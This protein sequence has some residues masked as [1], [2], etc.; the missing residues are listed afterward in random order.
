MQDYCNVTP[1][2]EKSRFNPEDKKVTKK[3]ASIR[4]KITIIFVTMLLVSGGGLG[5]LAI[6][7]AR[8]AVTEKVEIHLVDKA[9]DTANL[10]DEKISGFFQYMDGVARLPL[11]KNPAVSIDEKTTYLKKEL[12]NNPVFHRLDL[13]DMDGNRYVDIG[14]VVN[15]SNQE[16]YQEPMK[17]KHYVAD[18]MISNLDKAYVTFFSVPVYFDDG[19][20]HGVLVGSVLAEHLAG[21]LADVVVGETGYCY[22]LNGNADLIGHKD[23]ERS[24]QR[25]NPV[26]MAEKDPAYASTA[27][28]VK[29]ALSGTSHNIGF[30][31]FNG[32]KIISS[33]ARMDLADWIIFISAPRK[34]FMG[35][36]NKLR[37]NIFLIGFSIF[38]V[39]V[40][41]IYFVSR[42]ISS[43]IQT[44]TETLKDIANGDGDLT[45]RL[46]VQGNDE[47]TDLAIYFNQTI[48]KI[49]HSVATVAD[50]AI[51]M[52]NIGNNL[53]NNM[54]QTASSVNE[55]AAN[56][57]GVKKQ[58]QNQAAS[59]T[60]T[61]STMEEILRTIQNL[62]GSIETQSASVTQSSAAVE[63]MAGNIDSIT[64]IL[65]KNDT[66]VQ[67]LFN[68]TASGKKSLQQSNDVTQK[69]SKASGGLID[70]SNV[71]QS[72]ASQTN[73]LAMNAAIEAAH[74][75]DAGKGFAVVA[76]EI[77]KLAEE[78]SMQAKNITSVLT[79]LDTEID[80]LLKSS[81]VV[82]E[83]FNS[84]MNLSEQVKNASA[85]IMSAMTEQEN[86]TREVLAAIKSINSVTLEVKDGSLEMYKGG[87]KVAKEM[88]EL[89]N[90]TRII[91]ESMNEMATGVE[92]VNN[93]VQEVNTISIKNK[94]S[95]GVL[96]EV[97]GKFKI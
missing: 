43:S 79:S 90:L 39:S 55:I 12:G 35:A 8:L 10:L 56:I 57:N 78:S 81:Q 7:T 15:V 63:Q 65:S 95:I 72:I 16:F 42:K 51:T 66:S 96:S 82:E 88:R 76:D 62:N 40:I 26:K 58:T 32:V 36:I 34:E 71:I 1:P 14:H 92:Q 24:R 19:K 2:P 4:N 11:I 31:E 49:R 97:V 37:L 84:I 83:E 75:G 80:G 25:P 45:A 5:V 6:R 41:T 47:M 29:E 86:G 93:A 22:V 67:E 28:F 68:A 54:M 17:G 70:A 59:V 60:E 46:A 85:N 13:C 21:I 38:I 9:K 77:R 30:Y 23:L 74:A 27:K 94:E 89:Q 53:A 64:K 73:L 91:T 69:L 44:A 18:P 61:S 3:R 48:E 52:T 87:E 50:N 20:I 33:Y